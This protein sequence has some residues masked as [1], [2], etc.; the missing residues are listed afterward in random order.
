MYSPKT[1]NIVK[2][3]VLGYTTHINNQ[4]RNGEPID[5]VDLDCAFHDRKQIIDTYRT[6][7]W[8]YMKNVYGVT[9]DNIHNYIGKI[10]TN[11]G[12][13]SSSKYMLSPWAN[14]WSDYELL[15]HITSDDECSCIDVNDLF[16][17]D[18]IDCYSQHEI[19]LPRNTSFKLT[20]Y[21]IKNNKDDDRFPKKFYVLNMKI[22]KSIV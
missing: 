22:S 18:E 5:N 21:T 19:I 14:Y 2:N 4:L 9:K 20:S 15:I 6:V 11:K 13:T 16:G 8:G 1:K 10:F 3:Y 7:D 17:E 12:F